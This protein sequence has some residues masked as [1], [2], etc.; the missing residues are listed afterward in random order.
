VVVAVATKMV[1]DNLG[2]LIQAAAAVLVVA[3]QVVLV[4][5]VV[6]VDLVLLLS[7]I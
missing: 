2:Q 6:L 3:I 7:V 1:L 4:M 5:R